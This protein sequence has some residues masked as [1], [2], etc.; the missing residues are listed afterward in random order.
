MILPVL[1]NLED[2][3][4]KSRDLLG[5]QNDTTNYC[6]QEADTFAILT[7]PSLPFF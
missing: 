3:D 6:R 1:M 4:N 5:Y 7:L 2:E